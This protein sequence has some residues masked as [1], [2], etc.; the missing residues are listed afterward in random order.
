MKQQMISRIVLGLLAQNS[1][2]VGNFVQ[3]TPKLCYW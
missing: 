1:P 2:R 3:E